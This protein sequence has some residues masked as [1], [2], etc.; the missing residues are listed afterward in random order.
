[1]EKIA[2]IGLDGVPPFVLERIAEFMPALQTVLDGSGVIRLRST[3]PPWTPPAWISMITGVNPSR[4]GIYT[5]HNVLKTNTGFITEL[6]SF[7]SILYPTIYEVV[8]AMGLR[9]IYLNIPA[10]YPP[11]KLEKSIIVSD[12]ASPSIKVNHPEHHYLA[13]AF[14]KNLIAKEF[15]DL[16]KLRKALLERTASI[17]SAVKKAVEKH[18]PALLF[19]V[20]SELDWIMHQDPAFIS[21]ENIS[22]YKEILREID[23]LITYLHDKLDMKIM[24]VSDHGFKI[25]KKLLYLGTVLSKANIRMASISYGARKSKDI[26]SRLISWVSRHKKI[27][28]LAKKIALKTVGK[29]PSTRE[30]PYTS[31]DVLSLGGYCLY[32]S[33]RITPQKIKEQLSIFDDLINVYTCEEA[34]QD[35][36]RGSHPDIIVVPRNDAFIGY[37]SPD[38][39][40]I[41]TSIVPQHH[42]IGV[43]AIEGF[44]GYVDETNITGVFGLILTQLGLPLPSYSDRQL[45]EDVGIDYEINDKIYNRLLIAKKI[46][47]VRYS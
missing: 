22:F 41:K 37:N 27:K 13:E 17:V 16:E 4:H 43:L 28:L 10:S 31:V 9:G 35:K 26:K 25:Y 7:A 14:S 36:C 40:E 18:S 2:V 1:M 42:P 38:G 46:K 5:F 3:I 8:D 45:L 19:I 33:P 21:G 6:V 11:P 20:L 34:Y 32:L 47:R 23:G 24:I 12:W 39:S 15:T 44:I 30:I 29:V